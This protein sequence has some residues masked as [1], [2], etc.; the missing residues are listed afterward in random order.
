M[1]RKPETKL[2]TEEYESRRRRVG[3]GEPAMEGEARHYQDGQC[4]DAA[5]VEGKWLFLSGEACLGVSFRRDGQC[6]EVL[7]D[8]AGVSRG[9]S[10]ALRDA[11]RE[12]ARCGGGKDRTLD[13]SKDL[14]V[15]V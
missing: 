4:V 13:A 10:T 9:R 2:C 12:S 5:G 1:G 8:W 3:W 6:R 15:L 11:V 7:A 14:V